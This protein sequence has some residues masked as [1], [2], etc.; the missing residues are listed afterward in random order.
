MIAAMTQV[1]VQGR[2]PCKHK[3]CMLLGANPVPDTVMLLSNAVSPMARK[4]AGFC[5]SNDIDSLTWQ[6]Q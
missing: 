1:R 4:T 6:V 5:L 3:G 2:F